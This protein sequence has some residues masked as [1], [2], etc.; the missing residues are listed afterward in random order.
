M[1]LVCS[2]IEYEAACWDPY[3]EGQ[4][5][6]LDRVYKKAAKFANRTNDSVW[7]TW[8]QRRKIARVCT[9]PSSKHTRK[10][11]YGNL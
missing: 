9:V 1:S 4:T 7:K 10:N 8:A 5:N 11:E 2:V 6:A 3:R